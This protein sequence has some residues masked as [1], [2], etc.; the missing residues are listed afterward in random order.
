MMVRSG[1]SPPVCRNERP[2]CWASSPGS[3][4]HERAFGG[5]R[6]RQVGRLERGRAHQ[7][8][9]LDRV[10]VEP[11]MREA[12]ACRVGP[13]G[14]RRRVHPAPDDL[15]SPGRGS[16]AE[17]LAPG[18]EGLEEQVGELG[19]LGHHAAEAGRRDPVHASGLDHPRGEVGR[20]S[21]EQAQLADEGAWAMADDRRLGGVVGRRADHLDR[22]ALDHDQVVARVPGRERIVADLERFG[23]AIGTQA[24]QLPLTQLRVGEE[25]AR[26]VAGR[27]RAPCRRAVVHLVHRVSLVVR[28]V[29]RMSDSGR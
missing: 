19:V 22:A 27:V 18:E 5:Q 28:P 7:R 24:R 17:P 29:G 25:A 12:P 20:L 21:R 3:G 6:R 10:G 13:Q 11:D 8:A 26:R 23:A 15:E 14:E 16:F 4:P 2:R 9:A 1:C